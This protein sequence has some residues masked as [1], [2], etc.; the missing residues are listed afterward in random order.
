MIAKNTLL[1]C[2]RNIKLMFKLILLTAILL[3][4]LV[5]VMISIFSPVWDSLHSYF[6][7]ALPI[8]S[9]AFL[10]DIIPTAG[11]QIELFFQEE[12]SAL[13]I[14]AGYA[15]L[16]I[17]LVKFIFSLTMVPTGAVISSQMTEDFTKG[18]I[19]TCI[20]NIK[21]S[22]SYSLMSSLI[23][24]LLDIPF[25]VLIIYIGVCLAPSFGVFAVATTIILFVLYYSVRICF[26]SLWIPHIVIGEM[27]PVKALIKTVK[28]I[29]K[30]F[31][32][33]FIGNLAILSIIVL[34]AF[35]TMFVTVFTSLVLVI[36]AFM[37]LF[38]TFSLV[39]YC[40]IEKQDYFVESKI[41]C[42]TDKE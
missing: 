31:R 15:A 11:Q 14:T 22:I 12:S 19:A 36:P 29:G 41:T 24:L 13:W 38:L 2:L 32:K 28:N 10:A 20:E 16:A 7:D 6:S 3:T 30:T 34:V 5:V 17:F 35:G 33:L 25:S 18:Y 9:T 23:S 1:I 8:D 37:I 42:T 4:V 40:H 26:T 39:S 21:K 27:S